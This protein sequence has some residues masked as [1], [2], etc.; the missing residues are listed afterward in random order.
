M[1]E[2]V[3]VPTVFTTNRDRLLEHAVAH[4]FFQ[5]GVSRVANGGVRTHVGTFAPLDEARTARDAA[6]A[7]LSGRLHKP[8]V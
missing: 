7:L 3:W 2:P 6:L 4:S 8:A 5:R 1:D